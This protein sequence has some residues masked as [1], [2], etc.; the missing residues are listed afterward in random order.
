[1]CI[2]L[3]AFYSVLRKKSKHNQTK[4][5]KTK[6]P[7]PVP[8]GP[9]TMREKHKTKQTKQNKTKQKTELNARTLPTEFALPQGRKCSSLIPKVHILG[10]L[11]RLS[12]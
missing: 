9:K 8:P 2:L 7:P 4:Q 10:S 6:Q 12:K 3:D 1:L 5:N 11:R